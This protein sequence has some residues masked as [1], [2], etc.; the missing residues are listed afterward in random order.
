MRKHEEGAN[1]VAH[2]HGCK[3]MNEYKTRLK[4]E[5]DS[6]TKILDQIRELEG[7]EDIELAL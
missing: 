5:S 1:P 2:L 6:P 4:I 7:V 3:P